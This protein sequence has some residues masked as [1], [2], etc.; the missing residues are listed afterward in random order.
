MLKHDAA[1]YS[2]LY[3]RFWAMTHKMG[4]ALIFGGVF[5]LAIFVIHS[6]ITGLIVAVDTDQ[7]ANVL[8][9]YIAC[10]VL[11]SLVTIGLITL[12]RKFS[13]QIV[14]ERPQRRDTIMLASVAPQTV[15]EPPQN[16]FVRNFVDAM[17]PPAQKN[18]LEFRVSAGGVL[19]TKTIPAHYVK[20]FLECSTPKRAEWRGSVGTYGDLLRIAKHHGWVCNRT[21][22]ENGVVWGFGWHNPQRRLERLETILG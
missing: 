19:E 21:D 1:C 11:G 20:R 5:V 12:G 4:W 10:L 14:T 16:K 22:G 15:T 18:T 3:G 8:V 2:R 13:P 7:L 6:A 17:T 9:G